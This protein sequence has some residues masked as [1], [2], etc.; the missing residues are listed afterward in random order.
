MQLGD[1]RIE[2]FR[3]SERTKVILPVARQ[4]VPLVIYTVLV[5]VWVAML[6]IF[7]YS[8]FSPPPLFR[9]EHISPGYRIGWRVLIFV[10]LLFWFRVIGRYLL[11]WWQWHLA[12]REILL[13]EGD[14]FIVRRPVSIFGVTN[15][16]DLRHMHPFYQTEKHRALAFQYG[17]VQH[18]LF[19]MGLPSS[20]RDVLQ[21]TL[22]EWYFPDRDEDDDDF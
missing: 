12:N 11:R 4:W 14:V 5:V 18:H 8:F 22:N 17:G 3:N 10:W 15:A 1:T 19:A 9:G 6:A 20:E 13:V 16:Y 7:V 21:H 2:Y